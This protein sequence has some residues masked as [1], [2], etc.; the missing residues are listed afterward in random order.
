MARSNMLNARLAHVHAEWRTPLSATFAQ[1]AFGIA[2]LYASS[3]MPSVGFV[4]ES[5]ISAIGLQICFYMS[6]AGFA[7]ARHFRDAR[8]DGLR[9]T[10]TRIVWPLFAALFLVFI[11]L[12]SLPEFDAVTMLVGVGGLLAGL[13]PLAMAR[14]TLVPLPN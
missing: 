7:C 11:G 13:I 10:I 1:W 4:L 8:G 3:F 14:C 9:M 2:L 6:L 5:S 12:W